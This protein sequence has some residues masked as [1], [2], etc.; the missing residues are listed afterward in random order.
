MHGWGSVLLMLFKMARRRL[1]MYPW[2]QPW[3]GNSQISSPLRQLGWETL[4]TSLMKKKIR[5]SSH[6]IASLSLP[7]PG[8]ETLEDSVPY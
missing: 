1:E 4:E 7:V 6:V 8:A 2:K 3:L 5:G